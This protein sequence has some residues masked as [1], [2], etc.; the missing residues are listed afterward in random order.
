VTIVLVSRAL[1]RVVRLVALPLIGVGLV[2][3]GAVFTPAGLPVAH[4]QNASRPWLGVE[5]ATRKEPGAGVLV[6]HVMR[7]SPSEKAGI[8]DNDLILS[9]SGKEASAPR[10]IISE[11]RAHAPGDSLPVVV[12]RG[13]REIRMTV[14]LSP[15][16]DAGEMLRRDKVGTFSP[17]INGLAAVQ[18]SLPGSIGSLR[19]KVVVLDF[20]ASWCGVCKMMTPTLNE[21]HKKYAAQGLVVVGV[22]SDKH[23]VATSAT[24]KFG[25]DYAVGA[26]TH[27]KVFPGFNVPALPTIY[28][29]DKGG[30]VREV[31]VGFDSAH[32][33][34][35]EEMIKKLL[36]DKTP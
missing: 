5:L 32:L 33:Q 26:D 13:G 14:T 30:V 15:A 20:W 29:L 7:T 24:K 17:P 34:K 36:A 35:T 6:R 16:P 27:D 23:D 21:W 25:I 2:V 22:S 4:A 18:G 8:K 31:E 11:V 9:V 19:G 12:S 10:D 1:R 3:A 28:I